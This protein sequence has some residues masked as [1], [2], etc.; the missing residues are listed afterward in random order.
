MFLMKIIVILEH[1]TA[2]NFYMNV[3]LLLIKIHIYRMVQNKVTEMK[4]QSKNTKK[5]KNPIGTCGRKCHPR[6]LDWV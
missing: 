4:G 1:I 6:P 5:L 3:Y 2:L